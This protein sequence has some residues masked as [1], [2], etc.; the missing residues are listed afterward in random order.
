MIDMKFLDRKRIGYP[1]LAQSLLISLLLLAIFSGIWTKNETDSSTS[2]QTA[3][4]EVNERQDDNDF[5]KEYDITGYPDFS[6][7]VLEAKSAI[8]YDVTTQTEIFSQNTQKVLPI[9]SITKLMTALLV[10]ELIDNGDTITITE[11][12]VAQYG[13]SGLRVGETITAENLMQYALLSS[14]NDAAYALAHS[15]GEQILPKEGTAAFIDAMN[16][17]AKELGLTNTQF[18]NPTGLD[19]S[20]IETGAMSTVQDVSKLLAYLVENHPDLLQ[21]T[22]VE[23]S[24]IYNQNGEYHEGENTNPMVN[25][26]PNILASK[27]G[28]TD[29][30]GGNL[31]VSFD[32][33]FNRPIVITV[34]GSTYSGRFSDVK[35]LIRA[36]QKYLVYNE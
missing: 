10:Q 6:E 11:E 13:N 29:L 16:I 34:L 9:A 22:V 2:V 35:K 31:T 26:I 4:V 24:L 30:S 5:T 20:A 7:L 15:V 1:I 33:G 36:T 17:R 12:A 32:A 19:I 21:N 3:A 14:S 18:Q 28:Y 27:T 23:S 25:S 8:V